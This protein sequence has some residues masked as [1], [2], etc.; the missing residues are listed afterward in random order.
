M[1]EAEQV[2]VLTDVLAK[3]VS[4]DEFVIVEDGGGVYQDDGTYQP[5]LANV[6]RNLKGATHPA[7]AFSQTRM[8]PLSLREE[9]GG[10]EPVGDFRGDVGELARWWPRRE[11][12]GE[13]RAP[14]SLVLVEAAALVL[15]ATAAKARSMTGSPPRSPMSTAR[16]RSLNC[17]RA[18]ASAL[19]PSTNAWPRSPPP[20]TSSDPTRVIVS[21]ETDANQADN[22]TAHF[23]FPPPLQ[24]AGSGSRKSRFLL[25]IHP[26]VRS[27]PSF[28][29]DLRTAQADA[30]SG[31][32]GWPVFGP[33]RQ[34]RASVLDGREHDGMLDRVG[35]R[36]PT[37]SPH[38]KART[39]PHQNARSRLFLPM[40]LGGSMWK[41]RSAS[42]PRR[43]SC[44]STSARWLK[45]LS[46]W[47]MASSEAK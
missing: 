18:A 47:A 6:I 46:M 26:F 36:H 2:E 20:A 13:R 8:M 28:R 35:R 25:P 12:G 38:Q 11:G 9:R 24:R 37:A 22:Q 7:I 32:Q 4:D 33:P 43:A 23:R 34:R 27:A 17:A 42:S 16:C 40:Q 14:G 31:R 44:W 29:P 5:Y 21:A 10:S 30:R 3:V 41:R 19:R 1:T 39:Q 45:L 15:L